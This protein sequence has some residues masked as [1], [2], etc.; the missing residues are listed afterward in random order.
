MKQT[1]EDVVYSLTEECIAEIDGKIVYS[2]T[3]ICISE[4]EGDIV[5]SLKEKC[6]SETEGVQCLKSDRQMHL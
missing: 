3:E 1:G 5:S 2:L 6:I 4:T